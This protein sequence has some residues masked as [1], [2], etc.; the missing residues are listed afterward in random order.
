M[1]TEEQNQELFGSRMGMG[2]RDFLQRLLGAGA[3]GSGLAG[4]MSP[5]VAA[6]DEGGAGSEGPILIV[7]HQAGGNDSL[8]TVIPHSTAESQFYYDERPTM[9]IAP[10]DT[11][12][13]QDGMGLH[14]A[15]SGLKSLWEDGNLAII[16][17]V[18]YPNPIL[19]HFK[20]N[21]IWESTNPS[22]QV[23]SGWLGRYFDHRCSANGSEFDPFIGIE[24]LTGASLAFRTQGVDSAL[25]IKD[26]SLFDLV[27]DSKNT[28][29]LPDL[30]HTALKRTLQE[31]SE[32]A[33][34]IQTPTLEYIRTAMSAALSGSDEVKELVRVSEQTFP[35]NQFP[36]TWLGRDFENI[37]RFINGGAR[38]SVYY[39]VQGGYDTHSGQFGL[40]ASGKPI[41]GTH[42]DAL[43]EFSD[44]IGALSV[45][46]KRQGK[47]DR[48][49]IMTYSEFSRKIPQ[50][51]SSGTDHG[52]AGS[53]F[54]LGGGVQ[55]GLYGAMPGLAPESRIL[56]HSM[57][58]T[59]DYRQVYR[60]ILEQHM[61]LESSAAD[62]VLRVAPGSNSTLGFLGS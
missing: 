40:D 10:G 42:A 34:T 17:G 54:V 23:D 55:T 3:V 28:P 6:G 15:M 7:I 26:A 31:F 21:D 13:L 14:P 20:S 58:A 9:A 46:L 29:T 37:S 12:S 62:R 24:T 41:I 27:T 30:D 39:A 18:G 33:E 16:N 43:K 59:T 2:R 50:N 11:L 52:V 49:V 36:D 38:T 47:W 8:N 5:F 61:D 35:E 53:M 56:N 22:G 48:V 32:R 51:G 45:E 4:V 60:T 25:T 1:N 44:A 19:S 57:A